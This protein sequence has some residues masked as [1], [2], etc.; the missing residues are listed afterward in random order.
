MPPT[1]ACLRISRR[2]TL[3]PVTIAALPSCTAISRRPFKTCAAAGI[4]RHTKSDTYPVN[5]FIGVPFPKRT[6]FNP[7]CT[8]LERRLHLLVPTVVEQPGSYQFPA[9]GLDYSPISPTW[10]QQGIRT[11]QVSFPKRMARIEN[12]VFVRV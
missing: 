10:I 5:S 6:L 12:H 9:G 1:G 3:A 11:H 7:L 8:D 2:L 4:I